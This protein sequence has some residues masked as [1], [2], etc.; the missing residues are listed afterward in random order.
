MFVNAQRDAA[1][2]EAAMSSWIEAEQMDEELQAKTRSLVFKVATE[3]PHSPEEVV[4]ILR[5]TTDA[6][7]EM[8]GE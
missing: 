2:F 7:R 8:E 4:K 1:R 6:I 5:S 3:G